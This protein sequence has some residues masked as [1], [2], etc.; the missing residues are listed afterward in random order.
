MDIQ[1]SSLLFQNVVILRHSL[2]GDT[3]FRVAS[4]LHTLGNCIHHL[5][6]YN[7]ALT[8]LEDALGLFQDIPGI[9]GKHIADT[10][11]SLG[12][13]HQS[14]SEMHEALNC[15]SNALKSRRGEEREGNLPLVSILVSLGAVSYTHCTL[16]TNLLG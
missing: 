16:P 7:D 10:Y 4:N 3:R 1:K 11:V 12:V 6:E 14:R 2:S 13:I 8:T 15:Y 5:G 9:E